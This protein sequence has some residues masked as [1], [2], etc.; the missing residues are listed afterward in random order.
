M[1]KNLFTT[2]LLSAIVA[3]S[4]L[5]AQRNNAPL[6]PER[7]Y[8]DA[9]FEYIRGDKLFNYVKTLSDSTI[10]EGRLAGSRGMERASKWAA[11]LYTEWGLE[12]FAVAPDYIQSFPHPCTEVQR[13]SGIEI[14]FPVADIIKKKHEHAYVAKSYP[15]AQ[16]WYA[17]GTSANGTITADVVYAGYGVCAPE[18]GYDDY[19]GIDVKGKIVLIEGETPNKSRDRDTLLMWYNHT[20][21]QSK[22]E[23]AVKHGAI[24]MLYNWVPGPNNGRDE[25][26]VYAYVTQPLVEELFIGT[27]KTY[28]ETIDKINKTKKPASFDMNKKA[29]ISM[30]TT[31]DKN[32][33]GKNVVGFVKGSDPVLC[34]EYI[35]VSAHLDH[36]GM[37]PHH[38]AGAN[39]NL[40][41]VAAMMGVAE[42]LSKSKI[43]PK[44]SV[45][46]INLDGEEAGLTGSTY[47]TN[48]PLVPKESVKLI[49]NLEQVGM[50]NG[51]SVSY[52]YRTPEI[53]KYFEKTS[54][55]HPLMRFYQG[56]TQ[57]I[58]RPRTDGAVFMKAGYP[59]VDMRAFGSR[60][61]FYH[62]PRDDWPTMDPHTLRAASEF[63][64]WSVINA[65]DE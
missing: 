50:G 58:T 38:I 30:A 63:I 51:I 25:N 41:A 52:G 31:Y 20:L 57:H 61:G 62:D 17:G 1:K 55:E 43:K 39:D 64:F 46:F 22:V 27:G 3:V 9:V 13:E 6:T 29:T 11:D 21:H 49:I 24:G 60:R 59:T 53:A 32:A 4:P 65:A 47:Y 40:S 44:R 10:Y 48:S 35:I 23:N 5:F 7:A 42:A 54:A 8:N 45:I 28:K 12:K 19:A 26:F 36:L 16:Y 33:T 34:N 37:I 18:L 15:W 14:L 56:S 2:I